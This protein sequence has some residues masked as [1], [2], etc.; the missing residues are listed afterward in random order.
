MNQ[1]QLN[2]LNKAQLIEAYIEQATPKQLTEEEVQ[3]LQDDLNQFNNGTNKGLTVANYIKA[4]QT[5]TADERKQLPLVKLNPVNLVVTKQVTRN[6]NYKGLTPNQER[7]VNY[8]KEVG[9]PQ[10]KDEVAKGLNEENAGKILAT[11]QQMRNTNRP[12]DERTS[13]IIYIEPDG[14]ITHKFYITGLITDEIR[15]EASMVTTS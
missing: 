10:T 11:L 7:I 13:M 1:E 9:Q 8:F 15:A 6:S 5:L 14:K 2:K 4:V 3:A 12:E